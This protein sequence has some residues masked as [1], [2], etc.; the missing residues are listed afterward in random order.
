MK[1]SEGIIREP[2]KIL[3]R[4]KTNLLKIEEVFFELCALGGNYHVT[5][6]L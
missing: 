2:H 3:K 5:V 1:V 4:L 6:S